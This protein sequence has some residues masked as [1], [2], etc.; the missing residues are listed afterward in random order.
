MSGKYDIDRDLAIWRLK[1]NLA[2]KNAEIERLRESI[3][4]KLDSL[5][6]E[7]QNGIS[8]DEVRNIYYLV[9]TKKQIDDAEKEAKELLKHF[10]PLEES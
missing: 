2:E 6:D 10:T 9:W 4:P 1:R 7:F 8:Y 3:K 5:I